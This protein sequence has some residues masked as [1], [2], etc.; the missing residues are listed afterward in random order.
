MTPAIGAQYSAPWGRY[1]VYRVE[2]DHVVLRDLDRPSGFV[3]PSSAKLAAEYSLEQAAPAYMPPEQLAAEPAA[4]AP[5]IA[6]DP[7]PTRPP[8]IADGRR[9][10]PCCGQP[11]NMFAVVGEDLEYCWRCYGVTE[12]PRREATGALSTTWEPDHEA[13]DYASRADVGSFAP[14]PPA[15][16]TRQTP[17]RKPARVKP[18]DWRAN[19]GGRPS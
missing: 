2:G 17:P 9:R 11:A 6:A 8:P 16:R 18:E 3:M 19:T 1:V 7:P 5:P 4:A 12:A 13:E 14:P 10:C 15:E